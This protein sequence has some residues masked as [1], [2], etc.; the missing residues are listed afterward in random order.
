MS[1]PLV[2]D[3]TLIEN[4]LVALAPERGLYFACSCVE[5]LLPVAALWSE[6]IAMDVRRT[7]NEAWLLTGEDLP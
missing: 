5:R 3:M 4:E 1:N 7:L 6:E 2:D